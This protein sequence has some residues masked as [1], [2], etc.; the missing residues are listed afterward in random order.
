VQLGGYPHRR[1]R[2]P[3]SSVPEPRLENASSRLLTLIACA[4]M[5]LVC[6]CFNTEIKA[7]A[8]DRQLTPP[9]AAVLQSAYQ[10]SG[11]SFATQQAL[12][13]FDDAPQAAYTIGPGDAITVT[14]WGRA[15]LSGKHLVGPDGNIQLPFVGSV[16]V[17]GLTADGAADKLD[18]ALSDRYVGAIATVQIDDYTDNQVTVLGHVS[19]PGVQ[20]F[21]APPTLLEALAKAGVPSS[22]TG[23]DSGRRSESFTRCAIFRGHDS[24]VWID[25]RPL[26]RG[27]SL[28]LNIRLHRN[29]LIYVPDSNDELVYVMGQVSKPGAY[30][31]S[32]NMSFLDALALAGGPNDNAQPGKIVLARPSRNF[33]QVIDLKQMIKGGGDANYALE[34]GDI[35]YVPK[36]GIASVGYVLQQISPLTQSALFAAALF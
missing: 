26:L 11:P 14:V 7:P 18:H 35:I 34:Q 32:S 24:V 17:G 31:L 3:R 1:A 33:Q 28:A 29:D 21:S 2:E 16:D 5:S 20:H 6:G 30:E 15:E 19:N 4:A 12:L 8:S 27:E 10:N 36:N 23:A 13:S 22:Q 9:P 25:L